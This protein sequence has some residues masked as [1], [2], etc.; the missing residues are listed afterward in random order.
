MREVA[1]SGG[2][3]LSRNIYPFPKGSK[4]GTFLYLVGGFATTGVYHA[5]VSMYATGFRGGLNPCKDMEGF[6]AQ[7]FAMFVE[8]LAIDLVK[9]SGHASNVT[10]WKM[11][12]FIWTACWLGYSQIWWVEGLTR[13]GLWNVDLKVLGYLG[14]SM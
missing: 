8:R 9:K 14:Y 2:I 4:I 1:R 6:I 10:G 7:A 3:A 13:A 5:I 12:G 11:F